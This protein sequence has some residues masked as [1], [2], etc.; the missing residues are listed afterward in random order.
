MERV[1]IFVGR[2]QPFTAGHYKCIEEAYKRTGLPTVIC[3]MKKDEKLDK[4]N[5][6]PTS[7]LVSLYNDLFKGND[8][9]AE[10][11]PVSSANIVAISE[12]LR[13]EEYNYEIA[14][15]T[16][17][18]DRLP[19]YTRQSINYHDIAGLPDDFQMIEVTRDEK[20]QD[21][22]SATMVRNSLLNND[23]AEFDRLTPMGMNKNVL[24]RVLKSQIYK[25][26][27]IPEGYRRFNRRPTLEE[28][29]SRLERM[30]RN[31]M[32]N[33]RYHR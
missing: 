13:K 10:V 22:I 14:A 8:K 4:K 29:V 12:E 6:F 27:G 21:N 15:W 28:R 24:F 25:V 17:G 33:R 31:E 3:M 5:P 18:S 2:F 26:Y 9:I 30:I 20:S 16:C 1:N 7:M 11:V 23:R 32:F 19:T